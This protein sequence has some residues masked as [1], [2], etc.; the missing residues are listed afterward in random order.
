MILGGDG[1]WKETLTL[2]TNGLFGDGC[3]LMQSN[4]KSQKP[5]QSHT[6]GPDKGSN[7]VREGCKKVDK[8]GLLS[9]QILLFAVKVSRHFWKWLEGWKVGRLEGWKVRRS[10]QGI[11]SFSCFLSFLVFGYVREMFWISCW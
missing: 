9:N 4:A 5:N 6:L 10:F 3:Y 1:H 8:Y 7:Y 2:E 11:L